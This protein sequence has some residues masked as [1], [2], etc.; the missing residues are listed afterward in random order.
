MMPTPPSM[1]TLLQRSL[2]RRR[3]C[4]TFSCLTALLLESAIA[5][6]SQPPSFSIEPVGQGPALAAPT[7]ATVITPSIDIRAIATNKA[8]IDS[9]G[10]NRK[11]VIVEIQPGIAIEHRGP[12]ATLRGSLAVSELGYLANG[13]ESRFLARARLDMSAKLV[14]NLLYL[15]AWLRVDPTFQDSMASRAD[16]ASSYLLQPQ[17]RADI[18][19]FVR[20][21]IN[22]SESLLAKVDY[23]VAH[24]T[25]LV[26]KTQTT[27]SRLQ[28]SF[29]FEHQPRPFGYSIEANT[30]TETNDLVQTRAL[31]TREARL[32]LTASVSNP[33]VFGIVGGRERVS[34]GSGA[35]AGSIYGGRLRWQPT[36]RTDINAQVERRY[37]G[38]GWQ[39]T[40]AHH[41]PTFAVDFAMRRTVSSQD[42]PGPV[43][44][45][46]QSVAAVLDAILITRFPDPNLRQQEVDRI[47]ASSGL[48][49]VA[50]DAITIYSTTAQVRQNASLQLGLLGKRNI[51]YAQVAFL[52]QIALELPGQPFPMTADYDSLQRSATLGWNLRVTALT[53][54]N[55]SAEWSRLAR[56]GGAQA[57]QYADQ[58]ALRGEVVLTLSSRSTATVGA[59]RLTIRSN[60]LNATDS[61][62][63]TAAYAGL[64]H[65]F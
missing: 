26:T 55:L 58:A 28:N 48:P 20:R 27:T 1:Q 16:A 19:P 10:Q 65:R 29:L 40:V 41:S 39:A 12:H 9:S 6:V 23:S 11:D 63:E 22:E 5:Q 24:V 2:L 53:T 46:G 64:R 7:P 14:D 54:T 47:I 38:T 31:D 25:D 4:C 49:N 30:E 51:V 34:L 37:F 8:L 32:W 3:S 57:G 21:R 18:S 45:K 62:P 59:R 36:D 35:T 17:K 44:A 56:I 52:K 43:F 15:D 60:F 42:T 50:T 13:N 33:L 61:A